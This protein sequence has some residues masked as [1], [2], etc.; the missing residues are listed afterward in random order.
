MGD[1]LTARAPLRERRQYEGEYD[2]GR[3]RRAAS[4]AVKRV[5]PNQFMVAGTEQRVYAVNL[6]LD[7]PCD[8]KDAE[9]HGRGCLHELAARLHNGDGKLIQSLGDI[10]L[11]TQKRAEEAERRTKRRKSA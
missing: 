8:C 7:T 10:L 5:G 1:A 3:L 6:D 2:P 9:Y 4:R 11:A